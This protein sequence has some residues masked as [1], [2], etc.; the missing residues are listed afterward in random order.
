MSDKGRRA[1]FWQLGLVLGFVVLAL[2]ISQLLKSG[3]EPPRH[4]DGQERRL[5]VQT[6]QVQPGAFRITF[7]TTGLVEARTVIGVVPEVNGRVIRVHEQ[8][9]AGGE[10]AAGETLF[11]IDPRDFELEIE[12]TEAEVARARTRFDLEQAEAKAAQ[13]E[14]HQS[15]GE[16]A[17]PP[18]LVARKPQMAEAR[19]NLHGAQAALATAKLALGRTRF[20][21]PFDG[22]VV[23]S[24]LAPGQYARAGQ[25]HGQVFDLASL[26]IRASLTDQQLTWLMATDNPDIQVRTRYLGRTASHAGVLR[27]GASVLEPATRFATVRIG[28]ADPDHRLVPGVFADVEINGPALEQVIQLPV[29]AL[30]KDGLIWEVDVDKRLASFKPQIVYGDD[31]TI[32]IGGLERPLTVVT[33]RLAGASEGAKV[34]TEDDSASD[35]TRRQSPASQAVM[36]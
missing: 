16:N 6:A 34:R 27:R 36:Q 11:A 1:G 21:L 19:A 28:F 22:R 32:V 35:A 33:S 24:D 23:E 18:D 15:Q 9:F 30:Q 7:T 17:R 3:Y 26:E 12:R 8:F 10:F 31:S 20:S 29:N 4:D 13:A 14:W 25:V 2:I 5:T